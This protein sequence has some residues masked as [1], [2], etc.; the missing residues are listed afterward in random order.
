VCVDPNGLLE[1]Q[2]ALR[3]DGRAMERDKDSATLASVGRHQNTRRQ[4]SETKDKQK[5]VER[6]VTTGQYL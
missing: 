6:V 1:D 5:N 4:M 3:R 2:Q